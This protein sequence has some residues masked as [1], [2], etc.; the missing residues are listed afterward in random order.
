MWG[1]YIEER[2]RYPLNF[3]IELTKKGDEFLSFEIKNGT[4]GHTPTF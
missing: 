3:D 4:K 2:G 1:F